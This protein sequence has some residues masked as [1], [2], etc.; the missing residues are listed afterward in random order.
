[1][2]AKLRAYA[3]LLRV[4]NSLTAVADVWAGVLIVR[5]T[6]EPLTVTAL[7]T[8]GSLLLYHAGM[9]FN[10]VFDAAID[11][12]ERPRRPIPSGR[13]SPES[14]LWLALGLFLGGGLIAATAY[15]I[16]GKSQAGLL[17]VIALMASIYAYNASLKATSVGPFAMGLCRGLNLCL[18]VA[19]ADSSG[20][21]LRTG[22][23]LGLLMMLYVVGLTRFA[24]HEADGVTRAPSRRLKLAVAAAVSMAALVGLAATPH[25]AGGLAGPLANVVSLTRW[26]FVWVVVALL[27]FRRY[28][29][30]ILQPTPRHI[31]SAVGNALQGII[32][33]DA[34]LAWGY[35]GP[36][37]GLAVFALLPPTLLMARFIPQT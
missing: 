36:Y 6:L 11:A 28:A 21:V 4:S 26:R 16:N 2:I 35:A 25:E 3:E 22:L 31:Q 19:V 32:L 18:G 9:V 20:E 30:A 8:A 27:I 34:T 33:I 15:V 14:A 12:D 5:G 7:L 37:W 23:P 29:A 1:M 17:V 24:K 13:V 10:D